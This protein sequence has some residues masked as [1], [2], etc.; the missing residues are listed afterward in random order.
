[1]RPLKNLKP[2]RKNMT[3]AELAASLRNLANPYN[4]Q[5]N[6][7]DDLIER[8][9]ELGEVNNQA[10]VG[11][12][13]ERLIMGLN[14]M[15]I[16]TIPINISALWNSASNGRPYDPAITDDEDSDAEPVILFPVNHFIYDQPIENH[17]QDFYKETAKNNFAYHPFSKDSNSIDQLPMI[18]LLQLEAFRDIIGKIYNDLLDYFSSNSC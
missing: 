10:E 2:H 18:T 5:K 14:V 1:M 4:L 9:E 15:C 13:L 6:K 11:I 16:D 8:I 17:Y 3:P 12:F 7:L